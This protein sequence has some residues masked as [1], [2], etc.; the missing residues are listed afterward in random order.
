LSQLEKH[1][2]TVIMNKAPESYAERES[3]LLVPLSAMPGDD[4]RGTLGSTSVELF[5]IMNDAGFSILHDLPNTPPDEFECPYSSVSAFAL[6]AQRIDLETL[7]MT[8]D[9]TF[10]ELET[11][12]NLV[13]SRSTGPTIKSEKEIL[14]R[15]AFM[16]FD[17]HGSLE[18]KQAFAAWS[19]QEAE[20]LDSYAAFEVL[21][22]LPQNKNK[23]WQNW[24]TAKDYSPQLVDDLKAAYGLEFSTIR[25]MQWVAEEQTLRYLESA[26]Q[27]DVEIW[28]DVPFYVG[29][30]E[31]WA[32]RQ[33]FNL[34]SDGNQLSQGGAAPS[35]TSDTGQIWGNATYNINPQDNPTATAKAID[36]WI[37]RLARSHKLNAGKVRLDHFIGFAEPY[38]IPT[39]A[40]DGLHGWR[41]GGMGNMLFDRLVQEFGNDL[42]F[43]PEDLGSMTEATPRLRDKYGL[44]S[45]K[46]AVRALTKDLPAGRYGSSQNNPDN[47]PE[48]SASFSVNH[49]SPTLIQALDGVRV[50]NPEE[51]NRYIEYLRQQVPSSNLNVH[52]SSAELAQCEMERVI[53]STARYAFIAIG[54]SLHLGPEAQYN[55]PG[56]VSPKNWSWRM[57]NADLAG[58]RR[59]APAW[60][61]L[62]KSSGRSPQVVN[63]NTESTVGIRSNVPRP[64]G[65]PRVF[66]G[67][68]ALNS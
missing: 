16:N 43:Y 45:T 61:A 47:Y 54:D 31:V 67:V 8:G 64:R 48:A 46:L 3:G 18:R 55:R 20:W 21:K 17:N 27:F 6:D 22:E 23:R 33:I 65:L 57:D 56:T 38:I 24:E 30:G 66:Y 11:Y 13:S 68:A 41:D 51:F 53:R 7:A 5:G 2:E 34:D 44:L 58:L 63:I 9:I 14:L 15:R 29:E 62:N 10:G 28:G 39:G 49:D 36:W 25:Y 26:R 12:Q 35:P 42:P 59:E 1:K 37:K 40:P 52:T 32:N 19:E 4:Y 60:R 50:S